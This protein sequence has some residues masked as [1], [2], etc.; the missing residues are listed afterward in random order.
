MWQLGERCA[1]LIHALIYFMLQI[2]GFRLVVEN[3]L[4]Y[5]YAAF[6]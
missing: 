4:L 1:K 2:E 5:K 3:V 6:F